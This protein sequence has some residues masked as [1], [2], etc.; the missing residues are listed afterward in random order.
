M[1]FVS[2]VVAA[3]LMVACGGDDS[4]TNPVPSNHAGTNNTNNQTSPPEVRCGDGTELVDGECRPSDSG[5]ASGEARI[6]DVCTPIDELCGEGTTYDAANGCVPESIVVCGDGTELVED[7][8]VP[9]ADICDDGTIRDPMSGLCVVAAEACDSNTIFDPDRNRCVPSQDV[10]AEGT[11]FDASLAR[12]L[13]GRA[14]YGDCSNLVALEGPIE[15][16][17]VLPAGECYAVADELEVRADAQITIEEGVVIVFERSAKL[18]LNPGKLVTHGTVQRPVYLTG[19]DEAAGHWAG[20]EAFDSGVDAIELSHTYIEYAGDGGREAAIYLEDDST[21]T[22]DSLVI[23]NT[24][25]YAIW[26]RQG[27]LVNMRSVTLRD[28]ALGDLYTSPEKVGAFDASSAFESTTPSTVYTDSVST[29]VVWSVPATYQLPRGLTVEAAASLTAQPG[30]RFEIGSARRVRV[31]GELSLVGTDTDRIVLSGIMPGAGSWEGIEFDN[32]QASNALEFVTVRHADAVSLAALDSN[33]RLNDVVVEVGAGTGLYLHDSSI[34]HA[35]PVQTTGH[36]LDLLVSPNVIADLT[37]SLQLGSGLF[38]VERDTL[39]ASGR[40]DVDYPLVFRGELEVPAGVKLTLAEGSTLSFPADEGLRINGGGFAAIGS[41]TSPILLTG[42]QAGPG[43]WRGV[44]LD[45]TRS[46][47][48]K[49]E[50]VT[51]EYG[52]SPSQWTSGING[53]LTIADNSTFSWNNVTLRESGG[54]GVNARSGTASD[55]TMITILD[56]PQVAGN[57]TSL[58]QLCGM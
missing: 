52:G 27:N 37:G 53:N 18:Q 33:L 36:T 17:I 38:E 21:V 44:Y 57:Y 56:M 28:N 22:A 3:V 7:R 49:L 25:G 10:C 24:A 6:D 58:A 40:W 20:I 13:P 46:P 5:C 31:F 35:G 50:H 51:I 30:T 1:Q 29:N 42:T 15:N 48:N 55:C 16:D 47:D 14:V 32:T 12:C 43:H 2:F 34:D 39:D 54:P 45:D 19:R 8:C 9:V 26:S 11:Y 4:G 23:S 41:A